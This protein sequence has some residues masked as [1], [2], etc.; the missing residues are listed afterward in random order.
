MIERQLRQ[1]TMLR[2]QGRD[3]LTSGAGV[4]CAH[5]LLV[6]LVLLQLRPAMPLP[7]EPPP[8]AVTLETGKHPELPRPIPAWRDVSVPAPRAEAPQFTIAPEP[9]S[10][11]EIVAAPA[12]PGESPVIASLAPG[13]GGVG[14]SSG[15]AGEESAD[16]GGSGLDLSGYLAQVARHI[17]SFRLPIR[18]QLG[19]GYIVRVYLHFRKDGTVISARLVQGSGVSKVDEA[20]ID[21][22]LRAQ[23]VPPIPPEFKLSEIEGVIPIVF[24]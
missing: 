18:Q 5:A 14:I 16:G 8:V 3:R 17:E 9:Q 10:A 22:V 23:P 12:P 1:S 6:L 15:G 4:V 11:P 24:R 2:V 21:Q 20:A 19:S 7:P 13:P